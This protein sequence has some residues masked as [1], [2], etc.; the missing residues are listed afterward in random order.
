M[1]KIEQF[2]Q[3]PSKSDAVPFIKNYFENDFEEEVE[4]CKRMASK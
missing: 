1:L 4:E 3:H 2:V